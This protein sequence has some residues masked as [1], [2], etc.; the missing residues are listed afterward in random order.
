[1]HLRLDTRLT[2]SEKQAEANGETGCHDDAD[3]IF[4]ELQLEV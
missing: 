1:M 3:K 4:A 2:R